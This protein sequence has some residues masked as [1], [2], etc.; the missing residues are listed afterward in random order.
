MHKVSISALF[1]YVY[2]FVYN[3]SDDKTLKW[4]LV[5]QSTGCCWAG[6]RVFQQRGPN[7]T[8]S[9]GSQHCLWYRAACS[10]ARKRGEAFDIM[11]HAL[12]HEKE[13]RPLILC[14]T[15]W[16]TKKRWDLWYCAA[17]SDTR[18][19]G[20]AFD[21]VLCALTHQK[22]VRPLILCCML[23]R[24]KKRWD[25]WYCAACLLW[26]KK[27]LR[28]LMLCCMFWHM[29]KR[30]DLSYHVAY[31]DNIET[32]VRPFISCCILWC[33]KKRWDLWYCAA[34]SDIQK[35]WGTIRIPLASHNPSVTVCSCAV[36][37]PQS[38]WCD[39][40]HGGPQP[41]EEGAAGHHQEPAGC[42]HT[43]RGPIWATG[44][45]HLQDCSI[46]FFLS[47]FLFYTQ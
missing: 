21:I 5:F 19:R 36:A 16:H 15:V 17:R 47:F 25:L 22:E 18:K 29:K 42:R 43:Y 3:V 40:V 30:W 46:F 27:E 7:G 32:E 31:S 2:Y 28:P 6:V 26:H 10:D 24:T 12:T 45:M 9:S 35:R 44:G 20:E 41:Y 8:G 23:W 37:G 14:C 11:L 39:G 38:L 34:Y 4:T 13:E 1:S 33:M